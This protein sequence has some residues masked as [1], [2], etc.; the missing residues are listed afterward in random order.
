MNKLN[1]GFRISSKDAST[2]FLPVA[3][4]PGANTVFDLTCA[5]YV[6]KLNRIYMFG[7]LTVNS[8]TFY[9]DS[10]WYIDLPQPQSTM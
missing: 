10:I 6:E 4:Y 9:N 7:G 8:S 1:V 3:N 5:V 2:E